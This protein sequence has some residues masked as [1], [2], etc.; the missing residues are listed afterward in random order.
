MEWLQVDGKEIPLLEAPQK[1]EA[2]QRR[3]L[4][5]LFKQKRLICAIFLALS[6][7]ALIYLLLR[8]VEYTAITKVL[9]KPSREFLNVSPTAIGNNAAIGLLPSP[10]VINTEI[11]IIKSPQLAERLVKDFPF[12]DEDGNV[13]QTL[14]DAQVKSQ[15]RW[16]KYLIQ[17]N[18]DKKSPVIEISMT[19]PYQQDWTAN[20]V[21]RAAELYLE[22][23]LKVHKTQGIGEFYDEQEKKLKI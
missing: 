7:P 8:P 4:Y 17:A 18:P 5:V 22:E 9:V 3:I 6:A 1:Y 13:P 12:P 10:E 11:Q 2:P 20:A 23:H 14:T 19:T 21:N 16:M 15:A